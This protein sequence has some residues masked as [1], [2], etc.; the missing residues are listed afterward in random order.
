MIMKTC[1][2]FEHVEAL[3]DGEAR[4][5][6]AVE[7]HLTG[8]ATCE[9][10]RTHLLQLRAAMRGAAPVLS[11]QQFSVFMDGIRTELSQSPP[12][13]RGF[14]ALTSL[15]AAALV[16]AVATF[17]I[18]NGSVPAPVRAN[19]VESVSTEIDGATVGWTDSGGGVTTIWITTSEDDL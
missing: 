4:N 11:D 18:F 19:G 6:G 12:R 3:V 1:R 2:W 16:I 7:A 5:A 10:H 17:S 8:C 9:A 14:W 15:A 13:G